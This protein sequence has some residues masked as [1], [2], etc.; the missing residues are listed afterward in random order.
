MQQT[1]KLKIS[2]KYNLQFLFYIYQLRTSLH[3][4]DMMVVILVSM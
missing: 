1:T 2:K 4:L 3:E